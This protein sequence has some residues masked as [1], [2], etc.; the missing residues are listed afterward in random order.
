MSQAYEAVKK[1]ANEFLY[2]LRIGIPVAIAPFAIPTS[3]VVAKEMTD[4]RNKKPITADP[5]F[6]MNEELSKEARKLLE[7][8]EFVDS[9]DAARTHIAET[10]RKLRDVVDIYHPV[11]AENERKGGSFK[12]SVFRSDVREIADYALARPFRLAGELTAFA[13]LSVCGY[14]A[15]R[16]TSQHPYVLL[17]PLITNL[18]S[19]G[20]AVRTVCQ[21][22]REKE[23]ERQHD[24]ESDRKTQEYLDKLRKIYIGTLDA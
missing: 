16:Y 3:L 5:R 23:L 6:Q 24:K 18:V 12:S 7:A 8:C 17:V 19:A 11:I 22:R 13:A 20:H 14:Y 9:D 4:Y 15:G 21:L 2:G 1:A 10:Y